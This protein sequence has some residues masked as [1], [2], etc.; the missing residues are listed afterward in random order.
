MRGTRNPVTVVPYTEYATVAALHDTI[1]VMIEMYSISFE[2][3][4]SETYGWT[5][6][7]RQSGRAVTPTPRSSM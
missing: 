2:R 6:T 5:M 1:V 4:F 3:E 7:H